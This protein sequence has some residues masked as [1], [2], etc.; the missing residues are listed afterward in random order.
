[1]TSPDR[2]RLFL[3]R[4]GEVTANRDYRYVGRRDDELTEL[5]RAQAK[6]LG[7]LFA[8]TSVRRLLSSPSRRALDTAGEIARAT[9][10]ELEVE[11]RL[12]EQSFGAWEG[13]SRDEVRALGA[14]N[15]AA[16]SEFDRSSSVA[17]PS[18]E[19]LV[20]T[21]ARCLELICELASS[22]EP[23]PVA[24]VSHVG[25]IKSILSAALD[26]SLERGRRLFLDLATVS[27]VDWGEPPLV[28]LFN[29]HGHLGWRSARWMG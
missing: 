23:G 11:D 17:P 18:G 22:N 10:L 28:R 20:A 4:H 29:A 9:D 26:L 13:L 16:L 2:L 14:E 3:V 24:L 27:V 25:P 19:A 1:M 8:E 12:R 5:G 7:E 21:Q 15:R 6:K